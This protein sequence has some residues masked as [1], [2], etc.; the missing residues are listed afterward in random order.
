MQQR[1]RNFL[2]RCSHSI[3]RVH[4][5]DDDGPVPAALVLLDAGR[6]VVRHN[7]KVLPHLALKSV[8]GKLLTKNGIRLAQSLQSVTGD[9]ASAT[10]AQTRAGEW[11]TIDHVVGQ[12]KLLAYHTHLVLKQ[13][14]DGFNQLKLQVIGQT[15]NVMMR[16]DRT[17]LY[18]VR[19][20]S[21]LSQETD[22]LQLTGLLLEYADELGTDNLALLLGVSHAC[23]LVQE[24]VGSI[25]IHQVGIQFVPKHAHHLLGFTLAQQ[26]VVYMD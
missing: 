16:L 9:G 10:Y 14:L 6:L 5:T 15:A 13:Q 24:A 23:Q 2:N 3:A 4:G 1:I 8:L 11:L 12:A 18:D 21:T 19:I 25:N 26:S 20:D 7:G 17:R 22:A